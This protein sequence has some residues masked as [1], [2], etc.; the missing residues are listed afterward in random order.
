[1]SGTKGPSLN[2]LFQ[3]SFFPTWW[4]ASSDRNSDRE[5]ICDKAVF[6]HPRTVSTAAVT[7][8]NGVW[9]FSGTTTQSMT[10]K[11]SASDGERESARWLVTVPSTE[12][13]D[14]VGAR[15]FGLG[16]SVIEEGEILVGLCDFVIIDEN[17]A[18]G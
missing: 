2:I 3:L 7:A 15:Y 4:R 10:S 9:D 6:I 18:R 14:L 5:S 11:T 8:V 1:M 17:V 16:R 12:A 13:H